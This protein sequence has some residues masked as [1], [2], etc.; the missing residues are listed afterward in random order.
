MDRRECDFYVIF[1]VAVLLLISFHAVIFVPDAK[2]M[3][4]VNEFSFSF[5]FERPEVDLNSSSIM[6]GHLPLSA[7]EDC[8]PLPCMGVKVLIPDD[9]KIE[10]VWLDGEEL[11]CAGNLLYQARWG[12]VEPI[13]GNGSYSLDIP[14]PVRRILAEVEYTGTYKWHGNKVAILNIFPVALD[15]ITGEVSY[16][17]E[18]ELR[19]ALRGKAGAGNEAVEPRIIE[20]IQPAGVPGLYEYLIITSEEMKPAFTQLVEWKTSRHGWV[21]ELKNITAKVVTVE[22]I[23]SRSEFWGDPLTHG[24]TGNDTQTQIRNFIRWAYY[25]WGTEYVLLGG[26]DEI[27]PARR[28]EVYASIS[29]SIPAD[30]YYAGLDGDWDLDGDGEY[31]EGAG[32][33]KGAEGEEADLLPEIKVGRATVDSVE[34]AG[35]FVNKVIRY[36]STRSVPYLNNTLFVGERLDMIPT[37][38][39]D[40]KDRIIELTLPETN[41]MLNVHTLYE[42]D[43]DFSS[44][45]F[46]QALDDGMHL[47]NHMGHGSI[48]RFAGIRIDDVGSLTN[49]QYFIM[50]SQACLIGAFDEEESG[51]TDSIAEHFISSPHGAVA[52]LVNSR[53]GWYSPGDTDGP[54]QKYDVEF[55]DAIFNEHIRLLGD[56]LYDAKTDLISQVYPTGP[57]RWCYMTLNLLGDPE[58]EIHFIEDRAHDLSVGELEVGEA[59]NGVPCQVRAS[60]TNLGSVDE[61]DV[62]VELYADGERVSIQSINVVANGTSQITFEWIPEFYGLREVMVLC[63]LSTDG[64]LSNNVVKKLIPVNWLVSGNEVIEDEGLILNVNLTI[65][66]SASFILKNS[67]LVFESLD[68][69]SL[70]FE[71][72]G[73]VSV[74]NSTIGCIDS[75]LGLVT[76]PGSIL[77]FESS[78]IADLGEERPS[79][80]MNITGIFYSESSNF[81]SVV[82][83]RIFESPGLKINTT[84]L[85]LFSPLEIRNCTSGHF[86]QVNIES[87]GNAVSFVN[88]K[89]LSFSGHIIAN[90]TGM[91]IINCSGLRVQEIRIEDCDEGLTIHD[92]TGIYLSNSTIVNNTYDFGITGRIPLHYHH[93]ISNNT[94]SGG[95]LTYL[96]NYSCGEIGPEGETGFLALVSSSDVNITGLSLGPNL[97]GLLLVNCTSISVFGNTISQNE[98]GIEVVDCTDV[99]AVG[100]DFIGNRLHVKADSIVLNGSY[101]EGGN[102]W[103]DYL[104][105]DSFS[106]PLQDQAQGDGIGDFPYVL[107]GSLV[108]HYPL[109]RRANVENLPPTADFEI[110]PDDI[111]T[112]E[113]AVFQD[114]SSDPDGRIVNWTWDLG[115]GTWIYSENATHVY[116]GNGNYTVTLW[117]MDDSRQ[118]NHTSRELTVSNRR[119]HAEFEYYPTFPEIGEEVRFTD[120][121]YDPDGEIFSW[122]WSFGD[123][124]YSNVKSPA[125]TYNGKGKFTVTLLV[126]DDDGEC[127]SVS[128]TITVG[129]EGP[130]ADFSYAPLFPY[131]DQEV[132][133]TDLSDDPDGTIVGWKWDFGDGT[134]SELRNPVHF[135]SDNG[136]YTVSL[137]VEDDSGARS[138]VEYEIEVLN[139]CPVPD[140]EIY[141][142]DP[143]SLEELTFTDRSFD[144]DGSI[145]Q[146]LWD[147]GD[148][149][150]STSGSPI[151]SYG[152]AGNYIITL[153]VWDDDG[154]YASHS[155]RLM[156]RNRPPVANFTFAPNMIYSLEEVRFNDS[157]R[158]LDG[159]I[160]FWNWSF[161][162]GTWSTEKNPT[163][164]YDV[165][166]K[167]NVTLRVV[168][169]GNDSSELR[170]SL[171]ILNRPPVAT[172]SW[173]IDSRMSTVIRFRSLSYDLDGSEMD[174]R[175]N[176][177]DGSESSIENPVHDFIREG[178]YT[179]S[180][181]VTDEYGE[182]AV[183][184]STVRVIMPDLS[185]ENITIFRRHDNS[186]IMEIKVTIANHREID[187]FDAGLS[188]LV[189]GVFLNSTKLSIGKNS[190]MEYVFSV[191]VPGGNHSLC[192]IIDYENM[193]YESNEDNNSLLVYV[194]NPLPSTSSEICIWGWVIILAMAIFLVMISVTRRN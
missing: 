122:N 170:I 66:H 161:G 23:T 97:Q 90:G 19:M 136:V 185:I 70:R 28:V 81:R 87:E 54:S 103:D 128:K 68:D 132:R 9:Y 72:L 171:I 164:R 145:V 61:N 82:S 52:M 157:S 57:M 1:T 16:Y 41:P 94:L 189:D 146:W 127:T 10:N 147:F 193:I 78:T 67:T 155:L 181:T 44:E 17:P 154:L 29:G 165:P 125:H 2:S 126:M 175:W 159:E 104:G 40:Y 177:G 141:P 3:E 32:S 77:H 96:E 55:F 26:D 5:H 187:V 118:W 63:N 178:V 152:K 120:L 105:T 188:L 22:W 79:I 30:I 191:A 33:G 142:S 8:P 111:L 45:A 21:P 53:E 107:N 80:E 112:G 169:D 176:F 84:D 98:V 173:E 158:D 101:E 139:R 62:P 43:G 35:N 75:G 91:A 168:D 119:P 27:I 65:D 109:M 39:G 163:H 88:S 151:H 13:S 51:V 160:I 59:Y 86:S 190:S 156:V 76:S 182:V 192:I 150:R 34:E 48:E 93:Y 31:G 60:I 194:E 74:Y 117:V 131:T 114:L 24:G 92:S 71:V 124:S 6:L 172:F 85:H 14:A 110:F 134:G 167:Y 144:P 64:W 100:N 135:Y 12:T 183:C 162:D 18:V 25:N 58:T 50:F 115:D 148:G 121:S 37:W 49:S 174:Y 4:S 129:N 113:P 149:N 69:R 47:V 137:V 7:R 56:A 15:V 123:G 95:R 108:D 116:S 130:R 138:I 38:G 153:T 102:Y 143:F 133:F 11:K 73:E 36:E 83:F 89:G 99:I 42:R 184:S 180:L 140:F 179:V 186:G 20:N 106:G 46:L 166:G